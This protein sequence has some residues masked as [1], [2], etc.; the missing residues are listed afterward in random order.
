VSD[1]GLPANGGYV[2]VTDIQDLWEQITKIGGISVPLSSGG[3]KTRIEPIAT[4]SN[5]LTKASITGRALNARMLA[6]LEGGRK[7]E[8][9]YYTSL[10]LT[11]R[12]VADPKLGK[13]VVLPVCSETGLPDVEGKQQF[14]V[15]TETTHFFSKVAPAPMLSMQP[16]TL[17]QTDVIVNIATSASLTPVKHARERAVERGVPLLLTLPSGSWSVHDNQDHPYL[18]L[19]NAQDSHLSMG[20]MTGTSLS[21]TYYDTVDGRRRWTYLSARGVRRS[22][23]NQKCVMKVTGEIMLIST[24]WAVWELPTGQHAGAAGDKIVYEDPNG[25]AV[26]LKG[27]IANYCNHFDLWTGGHRVTPCGYLTAEDV[28]DDRGNHTVYRLK[29]DPE[30][31]PITTNPLLTCV[32]YYG[33]VVSG[34][35]EATGDF[36]ETIGFCATRLNRSENYIK[37]FLR[38]KFVGNQIQQGVAILSIVDEGEAVG[39]DQIGYENVVVHKA[40]ASA[41]MRPD[42]SVVIGDRLAIYG[43]YMSKSVA[44]QSWLPPVFD[45]KPEMLNAIYE[46][47]YVNDQDLSLGCV[48]A[49]NGSIAAILGGSVR[50]GNSVSTTAGTA[51]SDFVKGPV[52]DGAN[53][54]TPR[55]LGTIN[56]GFSMFGR[57]T[58]D[59]KD[60]DLYVRMD[61]GK[62][63]V[64]NFL[65]FAASLVEF[66]KQFPYEKII[67]QRSAL[68][69]F[70]CARTPKNTY[71]VFVIT[72]THGNSTFVGQER[73]LWSTTSGY[74]KLTEGYA[75]CAETLPL[76]PIRGAFLPGLH[77][78]Y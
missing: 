24:G 69:W 70:I 6:A 54:Y 38:A 5:A 43:T 67:V 46:D 71:G 72:A 76:N 49:L 45:A 13:R 35:A 27:D 17:A 68:A 9:A 40:R 20:V 63:I 3:L 30:R 61:R 2:D 52:P 65:P 36:A 31:E 58:A 16:R 50:T 8:I 19:P 10:T 1:D 55:A 64:A 22:L 44:L 4:R 51:M 21:M 53:T 66:H 41:F 47:G 74:Q 29:Q 18:Y 75:A 23:D 56:N 37:A 28:K 12:V 34:P 77:T 25:E 11:G 78:P 48:C 33:D 59:L 14:E 42:R 73:A 7:E 57:G 39:P 62:S 60:G 26:V 32:R 15:F